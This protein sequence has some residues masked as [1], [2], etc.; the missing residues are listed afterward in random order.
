MTEAQIFKALGDPLRLEII[1]RLIGGSVQTLGNVSRDLGLTRQGIRRQIQVLADAGI[2]ELTPEGRKTH[3][4]LN[5]SALET[6][7]IFIAELE[8]QWERRLQALKRF[9]EAGEEK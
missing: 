1:K 6:A 5:R 4:S 8:E 2:L 7:R 9:A 3:V